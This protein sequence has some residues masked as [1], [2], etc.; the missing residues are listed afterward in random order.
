MTKKDID[1]ITEAVI[2]KMEE[3]IDPLFD[4]VKTEIKDIG[5]SVEG[6]ME[7]VGN[8]IDKVGDSVTS[9]GSSI[10]KW[11]KAIA[12]AVIV[13]IATAMGMNPAELIGQVQEFTGVELQEEVVAEEPMVEPVVESEVE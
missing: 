11:L 9:V 4:Q 5:D 8:N 10:S 12:V 1:K 7:S 2:A 13:A 3:K 6:V